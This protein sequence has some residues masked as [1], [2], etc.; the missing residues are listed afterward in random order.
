MLSGKLKRHLR[1]S[2]Q[3][4]KAKMCL[5]CNRLLSLNVV[6][7]PCGGREFIEIILDFQEVRDEQEE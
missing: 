5:Q 7:R 4:V 6:E 1:R 3:M 2:S